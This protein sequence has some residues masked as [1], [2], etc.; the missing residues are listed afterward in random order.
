MAVYG[1]NIRIFHQ[2]PAS[3]TVYNPKS[4]KKR[5]ST[6]QINH[7]PQGWYVSHHPGY[8][9]RDPDAA[10]QAWTDQLL[11]AWLAALRHTC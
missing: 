6:V 8:R 9:N 10:E 1:E 11:A 5:G 7:A 4:Q 3:I 2:Q